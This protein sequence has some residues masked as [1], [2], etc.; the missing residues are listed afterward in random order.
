MV[1]GR[2]PAEVKNKGG[3]QQSQR[4][5]TQ[6]PSLLLLSLPLLSIYTASTHSPSFQ[7]YQGVQENKHSTTQAKRKRVSSSHIGQE[8]AQTTKVKQAAV[9]RHTPTH[10]FDL[11]LT[12]YKQH[13]HPD[14]QEKTWLPQAQKHQ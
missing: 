4:V 6:R 13:P 5:S 8:I 14:T 7:D 12:Q 3:V 9:N 10:P 1:K 11:N 2:G